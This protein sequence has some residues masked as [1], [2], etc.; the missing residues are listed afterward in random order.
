MV[1]E[2]DTE[3]PLPYAEAI[4][5]GIGGARLEVVAGAGHLVNLE[6]PDETN[7]LLAAHLEGIR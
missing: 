7:R 3:T 1:G 5:A 4:A 2:L 6:R